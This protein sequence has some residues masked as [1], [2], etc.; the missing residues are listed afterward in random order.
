MVFGD[1]MLPPPES[2]ASEEAYEK[3]TA[4]VRA[5]VIEMREGLRQSSAGVPGI[6]R[7]LESGHLFRARM[8][9][10]VNLQHVLHRQL[11][12]SLRRGQAFVAE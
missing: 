5:R 10:V 2:E 12:V 11:C 6:A 1:P 8:R 7:M 3:L 4:E 9:L